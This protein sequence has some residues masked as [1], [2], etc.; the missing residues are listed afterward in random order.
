MRSSNEKSIA[1]G[2]RGKK[3]TNNFGLS[4]SVPVS[5]Y[6]RVPKA[7]RLQPSQQPTEEPDILTLPATP[8]FSGPNFVDRFKGGRSLTN[9]YRGDL[10]SSVPT[11]FLSRKLGTLSINP[12]V[13]VRKGSSQDGNDTDLDS[14]SVKSGKALP[15]EQPVGSYTLL[16]SL[17]EM[18]KNFPETAS[19]DI[20]QRRQSAAIEENRDVEQDEELEFEFDDD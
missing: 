9:N 19:T 11:D 3:A 7:P 20:K 8:D 12:K 5:V 17:E 18:A 16:Q 15:D 14:S 4:K 6:Q 10:P 2:K 1:F 13:I